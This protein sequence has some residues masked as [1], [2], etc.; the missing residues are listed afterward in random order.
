ISMAGNLS[1]LKSLNPYYG[2]NLLVEHP[3]G[4]W[5]LGAVFLCTTG[6]EALYSDMGHCGR[7]NIRI[8]WIFVKLMLVL[9]Y[10][11][12]TAWL[13]SHEGKTLDG[14][15][16]FYSLM[17]TWFLPFGIGIATIATVVASQAL[18]SGS[19][20]LINEAMRLN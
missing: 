10:M 11:G 19:F 6:A 4:F 18:I 16:P 20:T 15:N 5:L 2:I 3:G 8:S 17:P 12:Q 13:I 7:K 9:N 1:V 14:A